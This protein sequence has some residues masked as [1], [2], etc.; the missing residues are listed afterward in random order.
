MKQIRLI[1]R[2]IFVFVLLAGAAF[3]FFNYYHLIFQKKV[4]GEIV[5]VERVDA[6][7]AI[8]GGQPGGNPSKM[9]FSFAVSVKDRK[10]GE[11][12]VASSEDR[13]W[14][15]VQKGQCAEAVFYPY[16]PWELSKGSSYFNARLE[17][18]FDSCDKL[19]EN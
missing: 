4:I 9:V 11:I 7:L 12:F 14:A 10:T 13:R 6:P 2:L 15:V 19:P 8:I 3:I 17:R 5:G 18:L 16:G 1:S